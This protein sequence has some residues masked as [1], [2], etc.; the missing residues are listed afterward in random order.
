MNAQLPRFVEYG[1]VSSASQERRQTQEGQVVALERLR[2]SRP[3][4]PVLA[5]P[6]FEPRH[7]SAME[8]PLSERSEWTR[9]VEPLIRA[10]AVDE[11]RVAEFN[12]LVREQGLAK[13]RKGVVDAELA[14]R[15]AE[16]RLVA[17]TGG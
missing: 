4:R 9:V 1:R 16:A 14:V 3:G 10:G 7:V 6:V 5:E 12:R 2:A 11:V 8:V 15:L 17:A 13:A